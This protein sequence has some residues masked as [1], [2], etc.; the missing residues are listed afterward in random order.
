MP[1]EGEIRR[2][3]EEPVDAIFGA[4]TNSVL[5]LW[6]ES[7]FPTHGFAIRI[8]NHLMIADPFSFTMTVGD[9]VPVTVGESIKDRIKLEVVGSDRDC[10]NPRT[11]TAACQ[12]VLEIL[13]DPSSL[14]SPGIPSSSEALGS[15]S[16]SSTLGIADWGIPESS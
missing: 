9:N 7:L 3:P 5:Y 4:G 10:P 15:A 14:S 12:F 6:A 13:S 1:M 8:G 16:S 2:D 11:S